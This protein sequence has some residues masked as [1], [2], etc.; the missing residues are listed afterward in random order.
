MSRDAKETV[1]PDASLQK[2]SEAVNA[3]NINEREAKK[4]LAKPRED[5]KPAS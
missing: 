5:I 2:K 3:E 4:D 1:P